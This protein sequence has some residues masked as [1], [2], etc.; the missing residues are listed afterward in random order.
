MKQKTMKVICIILAVLMA[1]G[2]FAGV[3]TIFLH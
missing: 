1:S 3:L 2:T